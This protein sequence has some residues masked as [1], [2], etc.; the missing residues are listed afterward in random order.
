MPPG[1]STIPELQ[2]VTPS[3]LRD[4][5]AE[6]SPTS[7]WGAHQWNEELDIKTYTDQVAERIAA[8]GK[9]QMETVDL[10]ARDAA[11]QGSVLMRAAART[12]LDAGTAAHRLT[13]SAFIQAETMLLRM[14]S[15]P[16]MG[17]GRKQ[18]LALMPPEAYHDFRVSG[19]VVDVAVYQQSEIVLNWEL[20]QYGNF[21]IL[22]SP[23]AK[24]F[25]SVGAANAAAVATTLNGAVKALDK[26]IV[27]ANAANIAVGN[28][29]TIQEVNE[30]ANTHT[31]LNERVYVAGV[32]GANITIVGEGAN[33]GLRWDHA[34]AVTVSNKD[35]VYPVLFGGP[36]SLCKLYDS[37]T[38]E[39]GDV[40]GPEESG[41]LNQFKHIGWKYYGGYGRWVESWLV[42]GEYS[43]SQDA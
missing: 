7:R 33:G 1:V 39:F 21:K 12:A 11:M 32:D 26:L 24:T 4:A 6:I 23:F 19:K 41:L 42:R 25:A 34:H 29:L 31:A 22:V 16:Y 5:Y 40:V 36:F 20:A 9:N 10:L 27:V 37:G 2:D 30:T 3:V 13:E 17:N 18:W 8:V 38:G 15:P 14:K 28:W 35:T 43:S